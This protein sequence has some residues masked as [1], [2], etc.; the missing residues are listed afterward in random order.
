MKKGLLFVISGPSGTGKG[1]IC[2]EILRRM[3]ADLSISMT[4]RPPR[5]GE[6]HGENYYFVTEEEFLRIKADGGLLESACVY[7]NYYGTPKQMVL[8]RLELGRDVILEIDVQGALKIRDVYPEGIFIFI[9]PPS[10][11][12]LR[13]RI[14]ERGT[15]AP[16][17]I[18]RR[19]GEACR[20][21][22]YIDQYNYFVVNDKLAEAVE[23]VAS[24]MTAEHSRVDKD[25]KYITGQ[26]NAAEQKKL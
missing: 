26:Y 11:E 18:D 3:D 5:T 20:E 6:I 8:E 7:G 24:I 22:S 15:D 16:E 9:L 23:R 2:K 14:T 12:E 13:R 1:T 19:L 10:M 4:T 21:I 17:V 25:I